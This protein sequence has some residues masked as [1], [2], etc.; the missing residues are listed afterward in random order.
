MN[1]LKI[2]LY[3]NRRFFYNHGP[4][5]GDQFTFPDIIMHLKLLVP[6]VII[7]LISLATMGPADL[8][9]TEVTE[10]TEIVRSPLMQALAASDQ[11]VKAGNLTELAPSRL[12]LLIIGVILVGIAYRRS[13]TGF[14]DAQHN[15]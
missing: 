14:R 4:V 8:G 2:F 15:S 11:A 6:L 9:A 1:S 12:L 7:A 10:L 5:N 3:T 13:W